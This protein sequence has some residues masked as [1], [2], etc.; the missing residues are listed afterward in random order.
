MFNRTVE[1]ALLFSF[2]LARAGRATIHDAAANMKL[3]ESFLTQV[4]Y[5]MCKSGQITSFKGPGG[6]Y[7][8]M[9]GVTIYDVINSVATT[10]LFSRETLDKLSQ[11]SIEQRTLNLYSLRF[12]DAAYPLYDMQI[13]HA[14]QVVINSEIEKLDRMP[15]NGTIN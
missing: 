1:Y 4:T 3:S 5:K 10:D 11:G 12:A 2:Y 13:K 8:L 7:E 6:G 15:T 14:V 9:K